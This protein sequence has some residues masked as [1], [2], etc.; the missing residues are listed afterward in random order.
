MSETAYQAPRP[1][2][3]DYLAEIIEDV[4]ETAV[5][6]GFIYEAAPTGV[7]SSS[8]LGEASPQDGASNDPDSEKEPV[9]E[10]K[11]NKA[12]GRDDLTPLVMAHANKP[13][14]V[15]GSETTVGAAITQ[16]L[17]ENPVTE[18]TQE[19]AI[20]Y[21][22]QL[23]ANPA[24][25][26][27]ETEEAPEEEATG[28]SEEDDQPE[29]QSEEQ[30]EA[31]TQLAETEAQAQA[32]TE[33]TAEAEATPAAAQISENHAETE[34]AY[35]DQA[36][37]GLGPSNSE[38][39]L[40]A[41]KPKDTAKQAAKTI[42]KPSLVKAAPLAKVPENKPS[43]KKEAIKNSLPPK[44]IEVNNEGGK[45]LSEADTQ[46]RPVAAELPTAK[47]P[48]AAAIE[49]PSLDLAAQTEAESMPV[50]ELD[51]DFIL[52]EADG[53]EETEAVVPLELEPEAGVVVDP[54]KLAEDEDGLFETGEQFA[55]TAEPELSEANDLVEGEVIYLHAAVS[56]SVLGAQD[57]GALEGD[58]TFANNGPSTSE[59][60]TSGVA[61]R[62]VQTV[63]SLA[64]LQEG[65]ELGEPE[66]VEAAQEVLDEIIELAGKLEPRA[67]EEVAAETQEELEQLFIELLDG[68]DV[69]Y[70]EELIESLASSVAHGQL[71][72][73]LQKLKAG[74]KLNQLLSGIGTHEAIVKPLRDRNTLQQAIA[75]VYQLGHFAVNGFGLAA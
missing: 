72:P 11:K 47:N 62:E 4:T 71:T 34:V 21:V 64:Q 9:S 51:G 6:P 49:S 66:V 39:L 1:V 52:P 70:N 17:H 50:A 44:P 18:E 61:E 31:E 7:E 16:Y 67:G 74:E 42:P 40:E 75:Q 29:V 3:A 24:P 48:E 60:E 8:D 55:E 25:S 59:A 5:A 2:E 35:N 41:P 63:D 54:A 46:T 13:V 56:G 19:T 37:T 30:A 38:Q 69:A 33:Q 12:W 36:E 68:L 10:S 23:L 73:Y 65:L 20:S 32:E 57:T 22:R 27:K 53:L 14:M 58:E 28:K 43:A 26:K 45:P 15:N